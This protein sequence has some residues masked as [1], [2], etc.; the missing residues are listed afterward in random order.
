MPDAPALAFTRAG[1][2]ICSEREVRRLQARKRMTLIRPVSPH[3]P[4][5]GF[6]TAAPEHQVWRGHRVETHD[7]LAILCPFGRPGDLVWVREAWA[8]ARESTSYEY[9]DVSYFEWD[10]SLFGVPE[11]GAPDLTLHYRADGED[12]LPAEFS[13]PGGSEIP[14]RPPSSMPSWA[15]RLWL[16]I[17]R[18]HVAQARGL[19]S[20]HIGVSVVPSPYRTSR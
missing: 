11:P 15:A 20:W 5:D 17:H 14:W 19:W 18:V 2:V 13:M 8:P 9:G 3:P 1:T 6:E 12:R 10:D 4:R 7:Q 16:L